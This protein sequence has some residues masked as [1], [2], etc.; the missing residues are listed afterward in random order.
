MRCVQDELPQARQRGGHHLL[1]VDQD[2]D[3]PLTV[4]HALQTVVSH[5]GESAAQVERRDHRADEPFAPQPHRCSW[6]VGEP[7][8][9]EHRPSH[10]EQ[11]ADERMRC[12][13]VEVEV[14]ERRVGE[15]TNGVEEPKGAPPP[16]RRHEE[17]PPREQA[18]HTNLL[19][20]RDVQWQARRRE[21]GHERLGDGQDQVRQFEVRYDGVEGR[22]PQLQ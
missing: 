20:A 5:L 19:E 10:E 21:S 17:D 18:D 6:V 15:C 12:H 7:W 11:R 4:D 2:W 1:L 8:N 3:Q 22:L 16:G 9:C 13:V 14:A